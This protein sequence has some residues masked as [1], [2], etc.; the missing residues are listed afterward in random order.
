M[1]HLGV[2]HKGTLGWRGCHGVFWSLFFFYEWLVSN[3]KYLWELNYLNWQLVQ[4]TKILWK[5]YHMFISLSCVWVFA[6]PWTAAHQGSLSMG[7]SRQEYWSGLPFPSPGDPPNPRMEPGSPVLQ[8]DSL[9]PEP[10]GKPTCFVLRTDGSV[11]EG[12][13]IMH[14]TLKSTAPLSSLCV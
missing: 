11:K 14:S 2:T 10:P 3:Y 13:S 4:W 6:T 1:T 7:F 9:P 12:M 5:P 8:V